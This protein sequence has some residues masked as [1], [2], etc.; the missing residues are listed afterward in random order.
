M[1]QGYVLHRF[2]PLQ[3]FHQIRPLLE[4]RLIDIPLSVSWRRIVEVIDDST[5]R[6]YDTVHIAPFETGRA[7][8]G[9]NPYTVFRYLGRVTPDILVRHVHVFLLRYL[10]IFAT[11]PRKDNRASIRLPRGIAKYSRQSHSQHQSRMLPKG[12]DSQRKADDPCFA[13]SPL[14]DGVVIQEILIAGDDIVK[15]DIAFY[16]QFV[17]AQNGH[18]LINR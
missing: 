2:K 18:L 14:P 1:V 11:R 12:S 13:D 16:V 3:P 6:L 17:I 8:G 5:T 10:T 9:N 15:A 4:C 7:P